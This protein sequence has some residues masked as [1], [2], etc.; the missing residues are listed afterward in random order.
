MKQLLL[1]VG[2]ILAAIVNANAAMISLEVFEDS[3]LIMALGPING[4]SLGPLSGGGF[5]F[6]NI[7]VSVTGDSLGDL[8][9]SADAS[10]GNIS[11]FHNLTILATQFDI[12]PAST[13]LSF[14]NNFSV[15]VNG[16][17][18]G[19]VT[20]TNFVAP[21]NTPFGQTIAIVPAAQFFG[22]GQLFGQTGSTTLG[23]LTNFAETIVM[24][25]DASTSTDINGRS[26]MVAGVPEPSTWAMLLLGFLGLAFAFRRKLQVA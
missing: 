26:V 13:N 14:V 11:G 1:S 24:S 16:A 9:L 20:M 15:T 21:S 22:T 6:Q 19:P 17:S 25:F 23:S 2:L 18:P 3:N 12:A 4:G 5:F 7:S 10:T 8:S